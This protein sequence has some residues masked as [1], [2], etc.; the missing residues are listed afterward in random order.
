MPGF[1]CFYQA[2]RFTACPVLQAE[3]YRLTRYHTFMTWFCYKTLSDSTDIS[4]YQSLSQSD[5]SDWSLSQLFYMCM[6]LSISLHYTVSGVH[7]H[8]RAA[9]SPTAFAQKHEPHLNQSVWTMPLIGRKLGGIT[10]LYDKSIM[11]LKADNL[12]CP[13]IGSIWYA[14]ICYNFLHCSLV[15]NIFHRGTLSWIIVE[16]IWT[17]KIHTL[18]RF[19]RYNK[20]NLA[21]LAFCQFYPGNLL[22]HRNFF[23][24]VYWAFGV[25]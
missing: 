18:I 2:C 24:S 9:N 3:K 4:S 21:T 7:D 14:W 5:V 12:C 15:M 19:W 8:F 25:F 13:R 11:K 22:Y 1:L 17:L 10:M 6:V 20:V 23:L 16:W